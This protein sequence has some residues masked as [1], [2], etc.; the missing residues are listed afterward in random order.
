MLATELYLDRFPLLFEE[1]CAVV[2]PESWLRPHRNLLSHTKRNQWLRAH[3]HEQNQVVFDLAECSAIREKYGVLPTETLRGAR[4]HAG[5]TFAAQTLSLHNSLEG[6][7]RTAF[8]GRLRGAFKNSRD[9]SGLRLELSVATHFLRRGCS[10]IWPEFSDQNSGKPSFDL[11]VEDL[12]TDG[13]EI[14]CKSVSNDKGRRIDGETVAELALLVK[15]QMSFANDLTQGLAVVVTVLDRLPRHA[16]ELKALLKAI[17]RQV[18]TGESGVLDDGTRV[19]LRD[20]DGSV[21][22]QLDERDPALRQVLEA[23][24]QTTNVPT[25]V[26]GKRGRGALV[27]AFQ[28]AR[29]DTFLNEVFDTVADAAKRQ[30]SGRRAGLVVVGLEAIDAAALKSLAQHDHAASNDPSA[31]RLYVSR[32]LNRSDLSHLVGASFGSK[33]NLIDGNQVLTTDGSSYN[34]FKKESPLWHPAIESAFS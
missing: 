29:R 18:M 13:L 25:L 14:E 26:I 22:A 8:L 7:N 21:A 34:F 3:H 4:L 31:L 6:K 23:V 32:L 5:M 12:G 2:G 16:T 19:D 27:V 11:L 9:M 17:T 1:F 15:Q 10:L 30:L 33:G 20:F 24:T 28:S